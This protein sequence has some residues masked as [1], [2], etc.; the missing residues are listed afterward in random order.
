MG[1]SIHDIK[2]SLEQREALEMRAAGA[3]FDEI[4]EQQDTSKSTAKRRVD[5]ALTATLREPADQLR[6]LETHRLDRM[7][8][9]AMQAADIAIKNGRSPLF[10]LDR[11]IS[12]SARRAALLGL[13][14]PQRRVV[15]VVTEDAIDVAIRDLEAEIAAHESGGGGV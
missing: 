4:A 7:Y 14:A 9:I 2:L 6:E 12:I 3:T 13:D 1:T 5:A 10:A 11:M 15:N 8:L